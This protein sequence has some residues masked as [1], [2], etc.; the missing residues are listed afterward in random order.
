MRFCLAVLFLCL[1]PAGTQAQNYLPSNTGE[2]FCYL[3]SRGIPLTRGAGAMR[4]TIIEENTYVLFN[5]VWPEDVEE[6]KRKLGVSQARLSIDQK[7]L[8][9]PMLEA[10]KYYEYVGKLSSLL[11]R[12]VHAVTNDHP[13]I[14]FRG[15]WAFDPSLDMRTG[16]ISVTGRINDDQATLYIRR[17]SAFVWIKG[18][19]HPTARPELTVYFAQKDNEWVISS[20]DWGDDGKRRIELLEEFRRYAEDLTDELK[21]LLSEQVSKQVAARAKQ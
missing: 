18:Y 16:M 9:V 8:I 21:P 4:R 15:P 1:M 17:D 7:T 6:I 5:C 3:Q 20:I 13:R 2:K 14:I 10:P 19:G 11:G 12:K